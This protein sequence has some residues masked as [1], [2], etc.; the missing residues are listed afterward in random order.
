[1]PAA[2]PL[3]S[4]LPCP[5]CPR[6]NLQVCRVRSLMMNC[7]AR[8]LVSRS[9]PPSVVDCDPHPRCAANH[10]S[11]RCSGYQAW[12]LPHDPRYNR[13]MSRNYS[14]LPSSEI[15]SASP[16]SGHCTTVLGDDV[17]RSCHRTF[18]EITRWVEMN[19]AERYAV[20]QRIATLKLKPH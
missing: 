8:Y 13:A 5:A 19:D 6:A 10:V 17:C 9:A 20:N 1:M 14:L 11:R 3:P 2:S 16:C 15:T 4:P 18:D 12:S 7:A